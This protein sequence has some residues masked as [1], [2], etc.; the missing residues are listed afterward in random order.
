[1][2]DSPD[3]KTNSS[4]HL[5]RTLLLSIAF[6]SGATLMALE[7]LGFRVIDRTFGSALRETSVVISVFLGA[8][9]VGYWLGG[10]SGDRHP[11]PLA[12]AVPLL[13]AAAAIM[14]IP[15]FNDPLA[16]AVYESALPRGLHS[17][18]VTTVLF[19][20]PAAF[21]AAAYPIAVR[22]LTKD[23]TEAG[24]VAGM[25]SAISTAGSIVGS[26][27]TGFWLIDF[28]QSVNLTLE[29]I[30]LLSLMLAVS[31][32]MLDDRFTQSFPDRFQLHAL[33]G[34]VSVT[35][36][37]ALLIAGWL[38]ARLIS[39][40]LIAG[41]GPDFGTRVLLER[42]SPYH[43]IIVRDT[44]RVRTLEFGRIWQS[45]MKLDDP[46]GRGLKYTSYFHAPMM[47][48]ANPERVLFIG[49]GGGT[50]PRQFLH[51]YP[52]VVIDVVEIDQAVVEIA[53][54]YFGVSETDRLRIHAEDARAFVKRSESKW[55]VIIIDAYTSN[56]YGATIP[57]HL[58]TREFFDLCAEKMNPGG[59]I[60]FHVFSP[61]DA[62]ISRAISKTLL[63][64]FPEQIVFGG[65]E[66]LASASPFEGSRDELIASLRQRVALRLPHREYLQKEM[67]NIAETPLQT[68]GLPVL[69]DDYAP[70]DSLIRS[71]RDR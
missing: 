1:M 45:S 11:R 54:E 59:L 7:I 38:A 26:V 49:L 57:R 9:S 50:G 62:P 51:D 39:G 68:R 47:L 2:N 20:I 23:R 22:I 48:H 60:L 18:I 14:V 41:S 70:V 42:D 4:T 3:E 40:P 65:S 28:F 33:A 21:L 34:R 27:A 61:R 66:I 53:A 52:Q 16:N 63:M 36:V 55:D 37:L 17:L 58:T 64:V 43:H 46:L 71:Y 35:L 29:A 30:A 12:M 56:R 13:I 32:A 8:M 10:R 15:F 44:N 5:E 19:A 6:M 25:T 24:S 69:R 67:G 31:A